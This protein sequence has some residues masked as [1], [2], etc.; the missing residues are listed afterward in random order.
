[1]AKG[2]V[3][4]EKLISQVLPITAWKQAYEMV[5]NKEGIKILLVPSL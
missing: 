2:Q 5:E 1:M 3:D 4:A